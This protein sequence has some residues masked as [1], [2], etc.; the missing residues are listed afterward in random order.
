[1]DQEEKDLREL[2]ES[3]K[4]QIINLLDEHGLEVAN[5]KVVMLFSDGEVDERKLDQHLPLKDLRNCIAI[6]PGYWRFCYTKLL[7][8][9][10]SIILE[11]N[12][13]FLVLVHTFNYSKQ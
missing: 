8:E 7:I 2:V 6:S 13:K 10:H 9:I 1:M 12:W 11:V 3:D 4:Q 5:N